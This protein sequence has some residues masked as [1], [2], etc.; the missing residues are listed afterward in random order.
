MKTKCKIIFLFPISS[1]HQQPTRPPPPSAPNPAPPFL[2]RGPQI[3]PPDTL[4]DA[5]RHLPVLIAGKETQIAPLPARSGQ[6]PDGRA[7]H[8]V[9][10]G[11]DGNQSEFGARAVSGRFQAVARCHLGQG[12]LSEVGALRVWAPHSVADGGGGRGYGLS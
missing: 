10:D 11:H 3:S 12:G 7:V 4:P 6:N 2:T 1:L 8:A 9:F 5:K